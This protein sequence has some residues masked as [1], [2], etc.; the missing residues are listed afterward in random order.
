[1]ASLKTFSTVCDP[2]RT[3]LLFFI[4]VHKIR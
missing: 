3:L 2:Q 1:M 4:V